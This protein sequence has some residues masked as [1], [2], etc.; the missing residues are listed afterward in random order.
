MLTIGRDG[1][2]RVHGVIRLEEGSGPRILVAQQGDTQ[3]ACGSSD[4]DG[5]AGLVRLE[6]AF[7]DIRSRERVRVIVVPTGPPI[8]VTGVHEI[9]LEIVGEAPMTGEAFIRVR[10]GRPARRR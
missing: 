3:A 5:V 7:Q 10:Q 4:D 1:T 8:G 2:A 6:A 9:V